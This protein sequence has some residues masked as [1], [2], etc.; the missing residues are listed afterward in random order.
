LV[1]ISGLDQ[2]QFPLISAAL[3]VRGADGA[4]L[5]GLKKEQVT[6]LENGSPVPL[7]DLKER[8][9]GLEISVALDATASMT[10]Y[11]PD[12]RTRYQ[13][14]ADTLTEWAGQQSSG[15]S[16]HFNLFAG[17]ATPAT[18]LT[19]RSDWLAAFRGLPDPAGDARPATDSLTQAIQKAETTAVDPG[20]GRVVLWIASPLEAPQVAALPDLVSRAQ[21]IGM[22]LF[23][24]SVS[25]AVAIQSVGGQALQQAAAQTGGQ[26]FGYSGGGLLPNLDDWLNPLRGIY[27]LHY[28]SRA[29]TSG[30]QTLTARVQ[31]PG[32]PLESAPLTFPID[33][34]P[35]NP[36]LISPP[37]H[38]QRTCPAECVDPAGQLKP[39]QVP[40]RILVE[41]PDGHA[42][43]LAATRLYVDGKL[44]AENTKSPYNSF[45]WD[46][47]GLTASGA[48]RIAVEAVDS[49][50]LSRRS[51]ELP[52]QVQIVIPQRTWLQKLLARPGL[53]PG[54]AVFAG[55]LC[56]SLAA[57]YTRRRFPDWRTR[58]GALRLGR[59]SG[60]SQGAQG[61]RLVTR[62]EQSGRRPGDSRPGLLAAQLVRLGAD[63]RP[64]ADGPL[65]L[66][67]R[68][69]TLG[70][71]PARAEILVEDA[72]VDGLH[73]RLA[74]QEDGRIRLVDAGSVA[75]TWIN[76]E[77]LPSDGALLEHGDLISVGRALFRFETG[78][79]PHPR[80]VTIE[81]T[82]EYL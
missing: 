71:D 55:L 2:K 56:L 33:L 5:S 50:G 22:R 34:Q 52:V 24:W 51:L 47:S 1:R 27:S 78:A 82:N 14:I 16:D 64:S 61:D 74:P 18:D 38:I 42:R 28:T 57:L 43:T 69:V 65:R 26:F 11:T 3:D 46:L 32:G 17:A 7:D 53:A 63:E 29:H 77:L 21:K 9:S 68:E 41:F 73:A 58:L 66:P 49:L 6:L 19:Y 30:E 8:T 4:F 35:P 20:M 45:D 54:M 23:I 37:A 67:G 79:G 80:H 40:L 15:Q 59:G 70:S 60:R 39:G 75:G 62:A 36:I 72:S 25:P 81:K 12:G 31:Q 13:V 76:A 10:V 44:A 48:H